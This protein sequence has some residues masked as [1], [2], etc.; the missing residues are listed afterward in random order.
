MGM[1]KEAHV[2]PDTSV[3]LHD[4]PIPTITHPYHL[5]IKVHATSCNPKDW[6]MAT[7][8]LMTIS[9]C[10]NSGDD[11]SGTIVSVGSAVH[12]FRPGDRVAALHELGTQHGS[13]AEYAIAYSWTAFHLDES[14]SFEEACTVPMA[15]FMAAIGLFAMLKVTA[16]TWDVAKG[17]GER[18]LLVYGA[19]SAVG[20]E[21][22]ID[23]D[24][25]DVMIDYRKG[26]ENVLRKLRQALAGQELEYVF[27]SI[28]EKGSQDNYWPAMDP[29]NGK[30][31]FVLGGHREDI[32][33][34]I[35]QSTTM[36][37]SLWK[38]LTPVGERDRLGMGVGGRDFGFAYSRLIGN[39]LQEKKWKVHPFEIVDGGLRGLETALKKLREGKSSATKFVIRFSDTPDMKRRIGSR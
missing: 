16:G 6:K 12:D 3:K 20:S 7:G 13:Y 29:E 4:A 2:Q 14:T 31:T 33:Q 9:S 26:P 19:A 24:K 39:W 38:E 5:L 15:S 25:G 36:A 35:E 22:L 1:M 21:A 28:S 37:G 10:P 23:R 32:P 34:G 11:I 30:V 17:E 27:D 18:P 8:A